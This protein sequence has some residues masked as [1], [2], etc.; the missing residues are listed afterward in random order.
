[1]YFG[2]SDRMLVGPL[3]RL[4]VALGSRESPSTTST[5]RGTAATLVA[6]RPIVAPSRSCTQPRTCVGARRYSTLPIRA[7]GSSGASHALNVT[8]PT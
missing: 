1:M 6:A 7:A 5:A 2:F 4:R 3:T 8:S